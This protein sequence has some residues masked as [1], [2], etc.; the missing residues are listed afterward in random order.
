M[1][2]DLRIGM[3]EL[4]SFEVMS[5]QEREDRA[6]FFSTQL[7]RHC[8]ELVTR[9][10]DTCAAERNGAGPLPIETRKEAIKELLTLSLWLTVQSQAQKART[11][12]LDEFFGLA[13]AAAN[14]ILSTPAVL[15]VF[16]SY[17]ASLPQDQA[18]LTAA[19]NSVHKLHLNTA[20]D[21][22]FAIQ[23]ALID[24]KADR[25]TLL[26]E[27]LKAPHEDLP[28]LINEELPMVIA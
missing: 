26:K 11:Q 4:K 22:V 7:A 19:L 28:R 16:K 10:L 2:V 13:C 1:T 27:A 12:W 25:A 8:S 9:W 17:P 18:C 14:Q 23:Q 21:S 6:Y 15:Q 3:N 20:N 5:A 24:A